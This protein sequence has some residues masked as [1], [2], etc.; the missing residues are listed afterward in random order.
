MGRHRGPSRC[1]DSPVLAASRPFSATAAA[2]ASEFR[3]PVF[4]QRQTRS[5]AETAA[6]L[7]QILARHLASVARDL[8]RQKRDA[9]REQS[10][11][12]QREVVRAAASTIRAVHRKQLAEA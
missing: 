7:R 8:G 11:R 4:P 12:L 10:Y 6:W 1:G 3:H 2:E 5:E 9:A